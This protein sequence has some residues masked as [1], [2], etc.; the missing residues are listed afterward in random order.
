[1]NRL[2]VGVLPFPGEGVLPLPF[3]PGGADEPGA[4]IVPLHP[5]VSQTA[6]IKRSTQTKGREV[7]RFVSSFANGRLCM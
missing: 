1:M 6:K 7:L 2:A 3:P 4:G 5:A